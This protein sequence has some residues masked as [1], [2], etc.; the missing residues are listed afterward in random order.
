MNDDIYS[1]DTGE[2][3]VT[4][5]PK[6]WMQRAGTPAPAYDRATEGCFWRGAAWEIVQGAPMTPERITVIPV[7]AF[8]GRFTDAELIA[9]NAL[10][11]SGDAVAQLLLLKVSTATD[12][13]DLTSQ[14]VVNGLNYLVSAGTITA[15]RLP[16]LMALS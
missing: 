2:H 6:D 10:A 12:G 13:I 4:D 5:N 1:P 3:I 14:S 7:Y 11:Y 9:I 16:D 8:R 15:D